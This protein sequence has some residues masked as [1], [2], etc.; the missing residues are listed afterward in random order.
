MPI[1]IDD[2]D[3][4]ALVEL[5]RE[6]N[7]HGPTV[8]TYSQIAGVLVWVTA[9]KLNRGASAEG[10]SIAFLVERALSFSVKSPGGRKCFKQSEFQH[11]HV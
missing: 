5:L 9:G 10:Y 11:S 4:A 6:T 8:A 7:R 2:D 1:A 3:K